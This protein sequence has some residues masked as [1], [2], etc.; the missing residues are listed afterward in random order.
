M[1]TNLLIDVAGGVAAVNHHVQDELGLS[2]ITLHR[3]LMAQGARGHVAVAAPRDL[4][5]L[6]S[7]LQAQTIV[8]PEACREMIGMLARQQYLDQVPRLFDRD[9]LDGEYRLEGRFRVANKTG[10]VDGVRADAGLVWLDGRPVSYAVMT[11]TSGDGGRDLDA[12]AQL[13]CAEAGWILVSHLWPAGSGPPP[14]V[15]HPA[16]AWSRLH[17]AATTT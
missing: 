4:V 17:A 12:E 16:P 3:K 9:Q 11:E 14:L 1:A 13:V 2:P 6:L 8:S 15:V 5:A 10:M 7:G